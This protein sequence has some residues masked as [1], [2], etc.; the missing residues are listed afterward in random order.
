MQRVIERPRNRL[1]TVGM[2]VAMAGGMLLAVTYVAS[3]PDVVPVVG[4]LLFVG[5]LVLIGLGGG[6]KSLWRALW[7]LFP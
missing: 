1:T 4:W 6:L 5:G 3:P 2:Y 7:A